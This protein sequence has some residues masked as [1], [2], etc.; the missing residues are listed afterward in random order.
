M[1]FTYETLPGRVVFG[2]GRLAAVGDEAQL[3]GL[4]RALVISTPEQRGLAED[5]A[6]LLGDRVAGV[7]DKAVMHVPVGTVDDVMKAVTSRG[8]DGC[9]AVGGGSTVGLAKAIALRADLPILAV[10]TTYAGSEMTPVW[11]ITENGIKTTGRDLRVLP[12]TVIYDPAL[13]TSLPV[14]ISG[15][16]GMN[17]IAHCVEGL[18]S[19]TRNPVI[20]L[21][22]EEGIR[23]LGRSLPRI[24]DK[25]GDIEAR[26][27]AQYG[28][29]LAGSVLGAVGMAVHHK[30]CHTL[31]GSFNLPHAPVHTVMI[32]H[33]TWF[34]RDHAPEAM[35]AI[36]RAL[37][38]PA[39]DAAGA[40]YDLAATI[41]APTTLEEIGM[42]RQDLDKAAEIATTNPYYN[43]RPVDRA[44]I[45][46]LLDDAYYGV[47]PGS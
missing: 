29:W 45:R 8:V 22:A 11:G 39:A 34:N 7:Y 5:V 37:G 25:S 19:Q 28:A 14:A 16:S 41:Q 12:R 20:S 30:L 38:V 43:P 46:A 47:R 13:T 10:P 6:A 2:P 35:I 3:L 36:G 1:K 31:G 33:A 24:V 9:V 23:A 21:M 17:A 40:L 32:P 42:A 18:Y 26:A 27:E 15:C 44:G 4:K